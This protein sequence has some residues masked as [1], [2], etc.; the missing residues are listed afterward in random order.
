MTKNKQDTWAAVHCKHFFQ[1]LTLGENAN[2]YNGKLQ[3]EAVKVALQNILY[4]LDLTEK[5]VILTDSK[6][7]IE[8]LIKQKF[9]CHQIQNKQ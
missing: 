7:T 5:I 9:M 6:S 1:Y 3:V 8:L 2:H 4:R